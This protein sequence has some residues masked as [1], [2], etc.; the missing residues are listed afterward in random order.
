MIP[1]PDDTKLEVARL[2]ARGLADNDGSPEGRSA[3]AAL[4]RLADDPDSV[5]LVDVMDIGRYQFP[6]ITGAELRAAVE[7]AVLALDVRRVEASPPPA[8]EESASAPDPAPE[9]TPLHPPEHAGEHD[10]APGDGD[11]VCRQC[12]RTFRKKRRDQVFGTQRCAQRWGARVKAATAAGH[13]P[14][15][16]MVL[17]FERSWKTGSAIALTFVHQE[18]PPEPE[19]DAPGPVVTADDLDVYAAARREF[20]AEVAAAPKRRRR[21]N[22]PP[23][24]VTEARAR[25]RCLHCGKSMRGRHGSS[26]GGSARD[27]FCSNRCQT[28]HSRSRQ[29][30][31]P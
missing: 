6:T 17:P 5:T 1:I 14:G 25:R 21:R 26:R 2:I 16:G 27:V 13:E 11:G 18:D 7:E 3:A 12:G 15:S 10:G 23:A 4:R 31:S 9:P 28:L 30:V 20:N 19:A 29:A 24:N 22:E 8:V